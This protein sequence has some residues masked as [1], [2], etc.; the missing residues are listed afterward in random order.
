[1]FF[2]GMLSVVDCL[3]CFFQIE[4]LIRKD[5]GLD[6]ETHKCITVIS[7]SSVRIER[8]TW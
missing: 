7:G 6:L 4:N 3:P 8:N 2:T 1:M 5:F